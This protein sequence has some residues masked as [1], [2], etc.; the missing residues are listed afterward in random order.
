[1]TI[2]IKFIAQF[3][4]FFSILAK[5]LSM[6]KEI[7]RLIIAF[8]FLLSGGVKAIDPVGFSFKLEEYFSP[9]VFD[10][11]FLIPFSLTI[12][13]FVILLELILGLFLLLKIQIKTT[14]L[15]L[16]SLCVF[17]G[18]LTFY[19]AYYNVVTDCGCFG[20][21]IKFTP[22]QS[23]GKDIILLF[24]LTILWIY[25]KKSVPNTKF[26]IAKGWGAILCF[27]VFLYILFSGIYYEPLIDFRDYKIGTNIKT[28]KEKIAQNPSEYKLIY[29]LKNQKTGEELEI[30]QDDYINQNY[31]QMSQWK[32]LSEKTKSEL[33]KQ[34]YTSAIEHFKIET[35]E[36]KDVTDSILNAPKAVLLFSYKPERVKENELTKM[37][38]LVN[39]S[40]EEAVI[41]GISPQSET[42]KALPNATMDATAIKTIAR[43]NP[44]ILV[45][46][47]GKIISK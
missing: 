31:W 26:N 41:F 8:I 27:G 13:I 40:D 7:L 47:K 4:L 5:N 33:Y 11:E 16:I 34:G 15:S 43:S 14:L 30:N 25:E 19:S 18:F 12:S 9:T 22:W 29:T 39:Q 2:Y 35:I 32:I 37:E 46:E 42:F 6:F 20:D 36:G 45:L 23:F 28:E 10:L 24:L 1:M 21:A 3:Y 38:F 17:F 44:F